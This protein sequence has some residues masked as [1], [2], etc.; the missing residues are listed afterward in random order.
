MS[1][2]KLDKEA[3]AGLKACK[4]QL[5]QEDGGKKADK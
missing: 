5:L 4:E 2:P 1:Y 3:E